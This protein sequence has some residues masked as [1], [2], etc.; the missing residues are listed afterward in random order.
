MQALDLLAR[1]FSEVGVGLDFGITPNLVLGVDYMHGFMGSR[2]VTFT[3]PGAILT[4]VDRIS[5]D[6]DMVTARLS[7][8][9]GG[10]GGP[11]VARY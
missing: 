2:D 4:R 1:V 9:F 10:V 7:Y 6:I 11:V 8:K 3:A 5:Q